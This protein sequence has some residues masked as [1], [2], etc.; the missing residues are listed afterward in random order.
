MSVVVNGHKCPDAWALTRV[1]NDIIATSGVDVSPAD[2]V[3]I[4]L[5]VEALL[6]GDGGSNADDVARLAD[7]AV[8]ER[9]GDNFGE[10]IALWQVG[11]CTLLWHN[12]YDGDTCIAVASGIDYQVIFDDY[13]EDC[14]GNASRPDNYDED[15]WVAV[16]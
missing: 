11:G 6:F 8:Y 13:L 3:A 4:S 15:A 16:Y 12:D 14:R 1:V 10:Y 7:G 5:T 9:E 2:A